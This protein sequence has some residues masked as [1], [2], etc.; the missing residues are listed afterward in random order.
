M[1]TVF[2]VIDSYGSHEDYTTYVVGIFETREKAVMAP[3]EYETER[4]IIEVPLD[5]AGRYQ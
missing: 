1:K 3:Q 5:V 2:M 4:K